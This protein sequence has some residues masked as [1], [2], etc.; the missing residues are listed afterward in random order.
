[1][2]HN[3][4]V[5]ETTGRHELFTVRPAWHKLGQIVTEAQSWQEAMELAGLNWT[6]SK[7]G[8][9]S[10]D[11]SII[12]A[13]GIFR[14]DRTE[15][16]GFLGAVGNN[17]TPIQNR[18]QFDFVDSL[19]EVENGAHYESAGALGKGERVFCLARIPN[20]DFNIAGQ[21]KHESYLLFTNTH[22]GTESARCFITTVR[23]V[24]QNTLNQA[25]SKDGKSALRIRHSANAEAKLNDAKRLIRGTQQSIKS[26]N[27]KLDAL[28]N[29][30][31]TR[32]GLMSVI[33]RLFKKDEAEQKT[34]TGISK[35]SEKILSKILELYEDNDQNNFPEFKDTAYNFFNSYTRF[36]DHERPIR[37]T[38]A[39]AGKTDEYIRSASAMF[40]DPAQQKSE[41]LEV[42]LEA[43]KGAPSSNIHRIYSTPGQPTTPRSILDDVLDMGV[44]IN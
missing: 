25:I 35:S 16:T 36:I 34:E 12:S 40:G 39:V 24:C 8:L 42:I 41:A 15:A 6:V 37:R 2:A 1:M 21:D 5:N 44:R 18:Y 43:T 23:V 30:R 11:G 27:E 4:S 26:L 3:I 10:P 19:I 20:A 32:D 38:D 7:R 13:W 31:L 33:D 29:R 9:L 14:D 17:Y 22:N 28:A